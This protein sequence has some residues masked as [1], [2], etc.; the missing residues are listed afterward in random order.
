MTKYHWLTHGNVLTHNNVLTYFAVDGTRLY[1][2]Y[3]LS[4]LGWSTDYRGLC[5]QQ[6]FSQRYAK[7]F[8]TDTW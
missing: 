6:L 8:E 5:H 3:V 4:A 2:A 1:T 7:H